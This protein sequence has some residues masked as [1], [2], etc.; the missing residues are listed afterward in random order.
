MSPPF[1]LTQGDRLMK[2][3]QIITLSAYIGFGFA[4]GALVAWDVCH[5]IQDLSDLAF[6]IHKTGT[7]Q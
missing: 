1:L 5:I 6:P 3:L 4:V 2:A 7:R